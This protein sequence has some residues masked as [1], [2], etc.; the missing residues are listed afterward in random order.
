VQ[1]FGLISTYEKNLKNL[2]Y[3]LQI[4]FTYVDHGF[5]NASYGDHGHP[6][7]VFGLALCRGDVAYTLKCQLCVSAATRDFI[8]DI[9][10]PLSRA[11]INWHELCYVKY[12]NVNFFGEIDTDNKFPM[13]NSNYLLYN[14]QLY[15]NGTAMGL[16]SNL[17]KN[18]TE[19]AGN[20]M[21]A[22]GSASVPQ[23]NLH[24]YGMV[25]CSGDL[26]KVNCTKC[27]DYAVS[28]LPGL[29]DEDG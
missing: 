18:A 23:V 13:Q 10:C 19:M 20:Y 16:L 26:T 17:S 9:K 5:R 12:S 29:D 27:L 4:N 25:Q 6:D 24:V 22:S 7:W 28:Q 15:F 21:F 1:L 8:T 14:E 2:L 3:D 11:A